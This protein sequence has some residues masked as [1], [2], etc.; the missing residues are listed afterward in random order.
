M[1]C[2]PYV[3]QGDVIFTFGVE[4]DD[5][6]VVAIYELHTLDPDCNFTQTLWMFCI[7]DC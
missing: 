2:A 3:A 1:R 4:R 7:A 5:D 6:L